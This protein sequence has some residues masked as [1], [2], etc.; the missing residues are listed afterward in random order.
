MHTSMRFFLLAD[1]EGAPNDNAKL[2]VIPAP[3]D[4]ARLMPI[5]FQPY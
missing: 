4:K 3:S 1:G 5:L 2:C